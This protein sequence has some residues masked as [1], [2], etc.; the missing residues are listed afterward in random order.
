[1]GY[2]GPRAWPR[3]AMFLG[4]EPLPWAGWISPGISGYSVAMVW[5][6]PERG[7][8]STTCGSTARA[9]GH[10]SMGRMVP[11]RPECMALRGYLHRATFPLR[12]TP[13]SVGPMRP[14]ISGSSEEAFTP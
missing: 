13:A 10:G 14:E 12:E 4:H 3:L 2:T 1:M 6:R 9:N 8:H 5:T 11:A 7:G